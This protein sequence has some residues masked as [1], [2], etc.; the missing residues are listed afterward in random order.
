M[1]LF[2]SK[3]KACD[4]KTNQEENKID[5]EVVLEYWAGNH[6]CCS[7]AKIF[8]GAIQINAHFFDQEE[9]ENDIDPREFNNQE[10]HEVLME[11]L[12]GLSIVLE[13]EVLL[14]MEDSPEEILLKVKGKE[15][16]FLLV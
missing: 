3:W 11:Y 13:K 4:L 1:K 8:I 9:I 16:E 5:F 12:K 2:A 6:D 7:T 15:I 14:T 10:D